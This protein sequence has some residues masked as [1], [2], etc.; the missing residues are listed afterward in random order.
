MSWLERQIETYGEGFGEDVQRYMQ[1]A[2]LDK[3]FHDLSIWAS[4]ISGRSG[5]ASGGRYG[6]FSVIFLQKMDP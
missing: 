5:D 1:A 6:S 3:A 2:G 4:G